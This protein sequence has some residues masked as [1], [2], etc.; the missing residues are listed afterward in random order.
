M[1][2]TIGIHGLRQSGLWKRMPLIPLWDALAFVIWLT[3]FTRRSLRWRDGQYYIRDGQL[4]PVVPL[5][6]P[7]Q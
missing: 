1:M 7:R 3:S 4:V 6:E 2:W 5:T